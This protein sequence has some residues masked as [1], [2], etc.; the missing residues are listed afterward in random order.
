MPDFDFKMPLSGSSPGGGTAKTA[1]L[2]DF[3]GAG[4]DAAAAIKNTFNE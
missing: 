1:V 2:A 3:T 4:R